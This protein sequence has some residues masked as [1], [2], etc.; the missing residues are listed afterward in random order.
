MAML[1]IAIR[2]PAVGFVLA[3]VVAVL[4]LADA[5]LGTSSSRAVYDI[6]PDPA[7]GMPF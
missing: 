5:L 3:G 6:V 1:Q 4:I 2:Q 7:G